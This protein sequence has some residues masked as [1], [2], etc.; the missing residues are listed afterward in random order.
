M[1]TPDV[2]DGNFHFCRVMYQS[3]R[4]GRGGAGA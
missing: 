2:F 3:R 4:F 1:A